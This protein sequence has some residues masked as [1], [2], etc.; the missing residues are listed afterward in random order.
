MSPDGESPYA[1]PAS[2]LDVPGPP[3]LATR[4][5][6]FATFYM[7]LTFLTVGAFGAETAVDALG[8]QPVG[9]A[10]PALALAVLL[11]YYVSLEWLFGATV[12]KLLAGT[13]VVAPGRPRPTLAQ[14][15]ARTLARAIPFEAISLFLRREPIAWHDALSGTRVIQKR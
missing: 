6:R 10:L 11:A 2:R 7:D 15:V 1:P 5:Q 13:R 14:L 9:R 8:G 4:G 12:G 3:R